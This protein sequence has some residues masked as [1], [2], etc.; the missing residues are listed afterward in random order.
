MTRPL[1]GIRIVEIASFVAVPAAGT[2]L[3]DLGAEVIKVEVPEGELMRSATPHRSGFKGSGFTESAHFQMDN[4]GKRSLTLDL[5]RP[6][7]RKALERVIARA[8]I[9][10]TN[11]LPGRQERFGLDA[12]TLRTRDPR[13]IYASL[14]GYGSDGPERDRPAFDYAAYWSRTGIM[15]LMRDQGLDPSWQRGGVG[16]HAAALALTSG[17]LA[18]L[19]VRDQTGEG[20]VVEVSLMHTGFYIL[21]ND[22]APALASGME[23]VRHDRR[24]PRNPLWN[25][26]PTADDRWIFLVMIDSVRY[27]PELCKALGRE[28]L[29]DDPRFD[30]PRERFRNATALVEVLDETFRSRSLAGWESHLQGFNLI[31]APVRTVTEA[32]RDPQARAAGIFAEVEHPTA[33]VFETVRPPI[34]LSGHPMPSRQAAPG[35]GEHNESVLE[36]AGLSSDEIREALAD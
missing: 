27:W 5:T 33:G 30:D 23:P 36:E 9:V 12:K 17:V 22:V 15:D 29:C 24:R 10:L 31:W 19:R 13:L 16:D 11:M 7:A 1:E 4:R 32:V 25:H 28:A 21:G 8:D 14:S 35:L 3:A 2:L 18:A 34:R 20:Q 6:A 26:Y